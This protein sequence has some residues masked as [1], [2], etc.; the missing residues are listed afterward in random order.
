MIVRDAAASD[1]AAV[2][3][4]CRDYRALL[5]TR[6]KDNQ[7][8]VEICYP[9]DGYES[10]LMQLDV[11][12]SGSGGHIL[13][14][15]HEATVVGC[16][17]SHAIG[18]GIAEIKRVY[19]APEA[20]GSGAGRALCASLLRRLTDAGFVTVRLDTM[21]TLPEAMAMYVALGFRQRGPYAEVPE[22]IAHLL[23]FYEWRVS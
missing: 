12:H 18:P 6:A 14:A 23:R 17:M 4:L 9:S 11:K 20:R 8:A 1:M 10:L 2:R 16:A 22:G 13:V 15:E 19:V 3:A 5:V 21:A 7:E